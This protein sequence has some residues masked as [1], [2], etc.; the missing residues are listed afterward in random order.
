M[1]TD[2]KVFKGLF[3]YLF[4]ERKYFKH[5][6]NPEIARRVFED[7]VPCESEIGMEKRN[8]VREAVRKSKN[9]DDLDFALDGIFTGHSLVNVGGGSPR[10]IADPDA[11]GCWA[12]VVKASEE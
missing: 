12:N 2:R 5:Y 3:V 4:M 10:Y 6:E 11:N 9:V 7:Y 8:L 1:V